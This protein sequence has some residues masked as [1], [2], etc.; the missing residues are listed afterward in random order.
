[1]ATLRRLVDES[2]PAL[3]ALNPELPQWFNALVN[4]LLE[5]EPSRR[6]GSAKEVSELLEGCLAHV[7]QP[8]SV[9]LPAAL[10]KS[11]TS[12]ASGP[13]K[14]RIKGVLTM[15]SAFGIVLLGTFGWLSS[16]PPDLAG[17]WTGQDW[18]AV[19]LTKT[20]AMAY[21]GTYTDTFGKEP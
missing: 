20:N 13:R 10:P 7:Q 11:V 8:A 2:P 4:R 16:E 1:M 9:P 19:V 12:S 21:T 5:K 18:G 17:Q 14:S 6:F 15:L 3:A